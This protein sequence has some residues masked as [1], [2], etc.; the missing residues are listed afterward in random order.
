M[1]CVDGRDQLKIPDITIIYK[2]RE[3]NSER[4]NAPLC[5]FDVKDQSDDHCQRLL[6]AAFHAAD[7][8]HEGKVSYGFISVCTPWYTGRTVSV[9]HKDNF[10]GQ[11]A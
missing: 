11:R 4:P 9:H 8:K 6:V 10:S 3:N 5:R 2:E 1:W 7:F